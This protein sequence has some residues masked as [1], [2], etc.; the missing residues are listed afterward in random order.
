MILKYINLELYLMMMIVVGVICDWSST[1]GWICNVQNVINI[2][3]TCLR[4][5]K[6]RKGSN[7]SM[8]SVS[9]SLWLNLLLWFPAYKYNNDYWWW[10]F[11]WMRFWLMNC[12][13]Q[14]H[15]SN[16]GIRRRWSL[17]DMDKFENIIG[18]GIG[19]S[20]KIVNSPSQSMLAAFVL[21]HCN[22]YYPGG[23]S[24]CSPP[25]GH[26]WSRCW[27][28]SLLLL[29][30]IHICNSSIFTAPPAFRNRKTSLF[31]CLFLSFVSNGWIPN[32]HSS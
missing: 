14:L 10:S 30:L 20:S 25:D 1:N 5:Q 6:H 26:W 19:N 29:S 11:N 24:S 9:G 13:N 7:I 28:L 16:S 17:M 22:C 12:K 32:V 27:S 8:M 15:T 21:V 31:L 4:V 2:V 18:S 23:F 3:L